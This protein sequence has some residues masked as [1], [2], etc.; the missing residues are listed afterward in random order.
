VAC[1]RIKIGPV[2]S[3]CTQLPLFK[4]IKMEPDAMNLIED[5]VGDSLDLIGTGKDFL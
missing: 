2:F 5:N 1:K 3:P 4:D